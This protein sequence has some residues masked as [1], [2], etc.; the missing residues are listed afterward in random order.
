MQ[1]D[2]ATAQRILFGAGSAEKVGEMI[3]GDQP[4][5]LVTGSGKVDISAITDSLKKHTSGFT[6]FRITG[7]PTLRTIEDGLRV[8]RESN[9][10]SVVA[11]GG[12]SVL[13]GGKAI[14]VLATN[15]GDPVDFLEVIG[16]G[17]PLR[18]PSLPFIAMPTT[19]GTGSEV[20][21][22]A[23]L[24]V[25]ER[26]VKVSLRSP[27]MLPAVALID[28]TL[29]VSAPQNITAFTGMDAFSQL[30]EPFVSR[31][32]NFMVDLFAKEGIARVENSLVRAFVDGHDIEARTDMSFASLLGGVSLAN[33]GLGAVHGLAG[34]IG[35]LA[36]APHGAVCA[37]LLPVVVDKNIHAML[38]RDPENLALEKYRQIARTLLHKSDA[39]FDDLMDFLYRLKITLKIPPL[40]AFGLKQS[41]FELLVTNAQNSSSMKGNPIQLTIDE[42][43]SILEDSL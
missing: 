28:P 21:R 3:A 43:S 17:K 36:S 27:L 29:T 20:T 33:A 37:C 31:R 30:I 13:D 39:D 15:P 19:A 40:S 34:P 1:F 8:L 6:L 41:D 42:L 16:S 11:V 32:A 5:L 26:R 38:K 18:N 14:A 22:N 12:G 7:E 24:T 10:G 25:H 4:V 23:V 35:G 2:F 9:A